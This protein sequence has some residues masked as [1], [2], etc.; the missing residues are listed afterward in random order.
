LGAG[1]IGQSI[2]NKGRGEGLGTGAYQP[3]LDFGVYMYFVIVWAC[4]P[5]KEHRASPYRDIRTKQ[6]TWVLF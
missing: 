2:R 1:D 6:G 4:S 3:A 5:A